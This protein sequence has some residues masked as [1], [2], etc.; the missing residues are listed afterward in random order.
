MTRWPRSATAP[1]ASR[2]TCWPAVVIAF[3]TAGENRRE[4]GEPSTPKREF[5]RI[6]V[7]CA[8]IALPAARAQRPQVERVDGRDRRADAVEL[9]PGR[10]APLDRQLDEPRAL[11]D[12]EHQARVLEVVGGEAGGIVAVRGLDLRPAVLG[13]E[14]FPL[15]DQQLGRGV[16][17]VVLEADEGAAEKREPVQHHAPAE[18]DARLAREALVA[19]D[20]EL[21]VGA[22]EGAA[23]PRAP[24]GALQ[25]DQVEIAHVPAGQHVGV[26]PPHVGEEALEERALV[27]H[28]LAEAVAHPGN[29]ARESHPDAH[30][31]L[32]TE[33]AEL[34]RQDAHAGGEPAHLA[35]V[36]G[37]YEKVRREPIVYD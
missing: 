32:A 36:G 34:A 27:G 23:E 25:D 31:G 22:A 6:L 24:A 30:A 11:Q 8:A 4:A 26:D 14:E 19:A 10:E 28:R 21:V 35:L 5:I 18:H 15:A 1:A 13:G 3:A 17:A 37:A 29:V 12:L 9:H 33:R 16:E 2:I 7:A 20:I